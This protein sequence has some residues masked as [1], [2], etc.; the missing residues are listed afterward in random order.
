MRY[1][2]GIDIG[3]TSVKAIAFSAD[4]KV[5]FEQAIAYAMTHPKPDWSEQDPEE[6]VKALFQC[7][8]NVLQHFHPAPPILL[9]FS[10]V[11]HSLLAVNDQGTPI[12][13]CI[14]WAD[15]R[16]AA[17]ASRIQKEQK[18]TALYHK[19]GV[20]VH[21]MSP[22]CKL[23]W[24]RENEPLLFQKAFKFIG[25]KEYV[26][27]KLF[28]TYVVDSSIASATGLMNLKTIQWDPDILEETG[29]Q[30]NRLSR[31]VQIREIFTSPV[32]FPQL[33][34]VPFVIGGSDGAMANL[35]T[36]SGNEGSLVV[37]IG[38]SCA[39]R[40]IIRGAVTDQAMRTFCYHIKDDQ[41][42]LGGAGN[43]G[44]VVLQWLKEKFFVSAGNFPDFLALASGVQAGS[45]GLIFLPYILGERAP[46]WNASA[47]G[48]LFGLTVNHNRAHVIRASMEAVINCV[49]AI[50]MPI[51]ENR[52][53]QQIYVTGGFAQ[54]DEWVQILTDVFNLPVWVSETIE[55]A[56]WG[57]VKI[58]MEALGLTPA[59]EEKILKTF[60]PSPA[61]H[62][63]Y[64]QQ[65]KKFQHLYTL[66]KEE[67]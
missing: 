28:G 27:F 50:S 40:V 32:L 52:N 59:G 24:L 49:Y 44:A 33:K 42:L 60:N 29:L 23:L 16:A 57:A 21:A 53:I 64:Q 63:I 58:G 6:I 51:C 61:G 4:G 25:I 65:F 37:S 45:D 56:A 8:E 39:A 3:T 30:Q 26:F 47:K 46:M 55:N 48:V 18:S 7:V 67:F 22:F 36:S 12:S 17:I 5:L 2:L 41:Y 15:N 66:L 19:T 38:T 20:P 10:A 13:K 11:M 34:N 62:G 9:S 1:F 54:N 35:G 14:I 43:N 31:I